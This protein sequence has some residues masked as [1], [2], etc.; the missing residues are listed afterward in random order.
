[1]VE[2][3]ESGRKDW[4]G[5]DR[6]VL[7]S[8]AIGATAGGQGELQRSLVKRGSHL[9]KIVVLGQKS[10]IG[11]TRGIEQRSWLLSEKAEHVKNQPKLVVASMQTVLN[12]SCSSD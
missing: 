3:P 8:F 4:I 2:W 11:R 9:C 7:A 6:W 5:G 12:R 1:M 10:D